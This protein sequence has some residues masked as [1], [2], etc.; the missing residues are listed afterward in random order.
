MS[1]KAFLADFMTKASNGQILTA[2]Q[3]KYSE[4]TLRGY[5]MLQTE[6][7][8]FISK[9]EEKS[10]EPRNFDIPVHE[11]NYAF[12]E[13][14]QVFLVN[15]TELLKNSIGLI[16]SKLKAIL[17]YAF[18]KGYSTWNGSGLTISKEVSTQIALSKGEIKKLNLDTL[19]ETERRVLDI[20]IVQSFTGMRNETLKKFLQNPLA[21]IK[22]YNGNTYID[23]TANKTDKQSAIPLG[24][25]VNDIL[26]KYSSGIKVPSQQYIN[27]TIKIIAE[28]AG[29]N[30]HI[31]VRKTVK[32]EMQETLVPKSKKISTHTARRTL[33][34]L[35]TEAGF[36]AS[37]IMPISG[38][39]TE[40]QLNSYIKLDNVVKVNHLFGNKFFDTAI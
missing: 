27:R 21:Y 7:E 3:K 8:N 13:A 22:E 35:M 37:E 20:Q 17:K 14:F 34:S 6:Y 40:Y 30:N 18:R 5:K 23:I 28:K 4:S 9:N 19:S 32:G 33:I 25:I 26:L 16:L 38:H 15:D 10:E 11:I 2:K 36:K 1:F 24:K 29:L 12:A 31:V 39:S